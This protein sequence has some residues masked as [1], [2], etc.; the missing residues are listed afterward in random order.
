MRDGQVEVGSID[1][2][3][4]ASKYAKKYFLFRHNVFKLRRELSLRLIH[5]HLNYKSLPHR[6]PPM[7]SGF[8]G[9][10]VLNVDEVAVLA[11]NGE[12]G[13]VSLKD[14]EASTKR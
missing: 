3:D 5:R 7:H 8:K 1:L 14:G 12:I 9:A 2:A 6:R 4:E 13:L 10:I 11:E